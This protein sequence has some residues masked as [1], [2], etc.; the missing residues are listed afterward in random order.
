MQEEIK[1]ILENGVKAPSGSNSQ[2]WKFKIDSNRVYVFAE[3]QKDHPILNVNN[4]GTLIAHGALLENI[5]IASSHLGWKANIQVFP[6]KSNLNLIA[7]I[8]FEKNIVVVENLFDAIN[9][10]STNRKPYSQQQLTSQ[11][12][13]ELTNLGSNFEGLGVKFE[14]RAKE[15]EKL[16]IASS[17]NEIVMLENKTLHKL[18]FKEITWNERE[19]SERKMGF[20]LKSLEMNPGQRLALRLFSKWPV[21]NF[22]NKL[23]AAKGIAA[24]NAKIYSSVG[25]IGIITTRDIDEDFLKAGRLLERIWLTATNWGLGVH[26]VTGVLYLWQRIQDPNFKE[27][28]EEHRQRIKE[29]Y[30]IIADVFDVAPDQRI[31]ILFRIGQVDSPS[32]RSKRIQIEK[33]IEK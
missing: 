13:Q 20:F 12:K 19:D 22:F 8:D 14:D 6:D 1:T 30:K 4:R 25:A 27:I 9:K 29:A 18:F 26:L 11:Q 7:I 16:G 21:I 5:S 24:S 3:Y 31:A 15:L 28:S 10:R 23:G 17:V 33:L 2:P 32:A